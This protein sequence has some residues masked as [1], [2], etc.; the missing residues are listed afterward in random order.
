MTREE[1]DEGLNSSSAEVGA[2]A[3]KLYMLISSGNFTK[4]KIL[5]EEQK[6]LEV[7]YIHMIQATVMS[8]AFNNVRVIHI[9]IS[10]RDPSC[11]EIQQFDLQKKGH[12][13]VQD[14]SLHDR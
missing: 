4:S 14:L 9:T 13:C 10:P 12:Q 2:A 6:F 11:P 3:L 7:H 8:R 1:L 5:Q